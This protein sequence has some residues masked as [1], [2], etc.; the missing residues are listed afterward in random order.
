MNT[1]IL[2]AQAGP[3]AEPVALAQAI[4]LLA[5]GEVVAMPTETVYGLAGHAFDER[6]VL[7]IFAAKERPSFDPLIVHLAHQPNLSLQVLGEQ[8]LVLPAAIP[9]ALHAA[10]DA[11][12]LGCWPGPLTLVLPKHARVPELVSSGL[13]TVA[14][15]VPHHPV[16]Q[17][18]LTQSFPLAAP[19]A[20]RFGRISPTTAEA[21][22]QE[23][24]GRIPLILDGG[25]C[26][27]GLESTVI[28]IDTEGATPQLCLL[29][30]G[31]FALAQLEA[32]AG[33][34]IRTQVP[35]P[36][37]IRAPGMLKSHYAPESPLQLVE[38]PDEI[39]QLLS[40][41]TGRP[42]LLLL[43]PNSELKAQVEAL[44]GRTEA[45]SADGRIEDAGRNL[46]ASL[47]SLDGLDYLIA[48]LPPA[49]SGIAHAIRDRLFKAAG[50]G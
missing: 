50:R 33:S 37:E 25:P 11:L 47:R 28:G 18:L 16:A 39:S 31:H 32:I 8:A 20:N 45:L 2:N 26:A 3:A 35:H 48:E 6:A 7:K 27:I 5:A 41:R 30:P 17:A 10:L 4:S 1:Q 46:F 21:V 42:G 49:A 43:R 36:A 40:Q 19:S 12:M 23:L 9:A 29:R 34:T 14:L 24:N 13:P 22:Y 15:R 38:S 44:N